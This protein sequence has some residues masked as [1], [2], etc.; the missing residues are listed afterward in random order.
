ML[1]KQW[2]LTGNETILLDPLK[3]NNKACD[4]RVRS[5]RV[6]ST[7]VPYGLMRLYYWIHWKAVTKLVM[8]VSY[9][10]LRGFDPLS[11]DSFVPN[12]GV[13]S[14]RLV[15]I[16]FVSEAGVR[17]PCLVSTALSIAF[18]SKAGVRSPCLVSTGL[19]PIRRGF[20]P[21]GFKAL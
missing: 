6:V 19:E 9:P 4:A 13:R 14:P 15:S 8:P 2:F 10:I 3:G 5:P 20:D 11:V 18:V 12:A 21:L 17:S 16:A 7:V 1:N